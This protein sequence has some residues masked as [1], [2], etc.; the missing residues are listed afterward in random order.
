MNKTSQ[1]TRIDANEILDFPKLTIETIKS[2]I[3]LGSYQ[4][5]QALGYIGEHFNENGKY[6][7]YLSKN[8]EKLADS[9]VILARIQSR[10]VNII[11]YKVYIKYKPNVRS[12]RSIEGWL[13]SCKIRSR[14]VGCCS[15]IAAVVYY[16]S[17]GRYQDYQANPAGIMK[18]FIIKL[19]IIY[20]F[21]FNQLYCFR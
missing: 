15:H 9:K 16:I 6:L 18:I 20:V 14:T 11:K 4:I 12:C 10:H 13:C 7:I 3:T 2:K 5:K 8:S 21:Y 19:I 1:F 17:Y